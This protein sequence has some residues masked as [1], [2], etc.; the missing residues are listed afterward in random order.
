MHSDCVVESGLSS[1]MPASAATRLGGAMTALVCGAILLTAGLLTP[2]P[3]GHGTH[4]QL[5]LPSC[6]FMARTGYPCPTCGMTTSVAAAV[7]G[8]LAGAFKANAFGPPLTAALAVLT[9]A[10]LAQALTGRAALKCLRFGLWWA[11]GGAVG[12]LTCWGAA[13]AV[14]KATGRLPIS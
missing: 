4:E 7:R 10:G 9:A 5:G 14:G 2:D 12:I 3:T 1:S 13:V 6:S 11:V 8:R